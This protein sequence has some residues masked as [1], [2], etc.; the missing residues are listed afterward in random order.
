MRKS[1]KKGGTIG[2]VIFVVALVIL[3]LSL[4]IQSAYIVSE[5]RDDRYD[6]SVDENQYIRM[7]TYENY[8]QLL[9]ETLNDSRLGKKHSQTEEEIRALGYYYEAATLYKAYLTA[10][11]SGSAD[12]QEVRMKRY[13]EGA[14]EYA[15]E[16]DKID[17]L[18]GIK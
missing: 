12:L 8:H 14:G 18:L 3:S 16:A 11:D 1:G 4:V 6:Y 9:S 10:G 2:F 17:S 5:L 13:R 15:S 7:V